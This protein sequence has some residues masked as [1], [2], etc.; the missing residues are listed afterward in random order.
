MDLNFIFLYF[1]IGTWPSGTR[2]KDLGFNSNYWSCVKVSGKHIFSYCL[3]LLSN[4]GNRWNE[5]WWT[6]MIGFSYRK[7]AEFSEYLDL[8]VCSF[9]VYL[10]LHFQR[11][12]VYDNGTVRISLQG[13]KAIDHS[14]T[15][16]PNLRYDSVGSDENSFQYDFI[17]YSKYVIDLK[18]KNPKGHKPRFRR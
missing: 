12:F 18:K 13:S 3:C 8:Q 7:C 10:L 16:S 4:N 2:V 11:S 5:I 14:L 17:F 6:V 15:P 1:S 9:T